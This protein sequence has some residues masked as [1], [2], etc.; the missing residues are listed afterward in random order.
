MIS[1]YYQDIYI[2][3]DIKLEVVDFEVFARIVAI[4]L[5]EANKIVEAGPE[6]SLEES[7]IDVY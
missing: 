1:K 6:E 5:E 2:N 7:F 3:D 4:I